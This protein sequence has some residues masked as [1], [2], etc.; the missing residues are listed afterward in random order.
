MKC[1]SC[2]ELFKYTG[3]TAPSCTAYGCEDCGIGCDMPFKHES[4]SRCANAIADTATEAWEAVPVGSLTS[5]V[6][7]LAAASADRVR[8]GVVRTGEREPIPS[9]V[10]RGVFLRDHGRCQLCGER[11]ESAELDHVVPWS[12]GGSN[13]SDNLRVA[14]GTCNAKRSNIA[15][16]SDAKRPLPVATSCQVCSFQNHRPGTGPK[17]E[18]FCVQCRRTS[19]SFLINVL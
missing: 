9:E 13:R 1:A 17:V 8:S 18:A 10:R 15:H 3:C 5:S 14:C 2:G 6:A 4:L 11:A 16:I 12:A 19:T 7:E